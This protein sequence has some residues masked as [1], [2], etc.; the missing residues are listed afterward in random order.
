[1][2]PNWRPSRAARKADE[3]KTKLDRKA[4]EEREKKKVRLRDRRCRFP[5]CGC[6][7]L[8][9]RLEVSHSGGHKGMGGNPSGDRS[10]AESMVLLCVTRHQ[11]SLTSVHRG[12]IRTVYLT[13]RSYAGPVAWLVDS[14]TL[15]R[16]RHLLPARCQGL[17]IDAEG[18]VEVARE[19]GQNLLAPL[20]DWQEQLLCLLATMDA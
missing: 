11:D 15:A 8:K 3:R 18:F 1:M 20:E 16:Y 7:K 5:R 13:D 9:L 6:H 10:L 4:H 17:C 12:T 2:T 14:G 19:I